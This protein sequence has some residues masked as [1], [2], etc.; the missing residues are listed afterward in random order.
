MR[1]KLASWAFVMAI[2]VVLM[3][4]PSH[5]AD[6]KIYPAS[7]CQVT[8]GNADDLWYRSSSRLEN[9]GS[10]LI[11][12][13]CPVVRDLPL[14]DEPTA[15]VYGR[16]VHYG[17]Q[18]LKCRLNIRMSNGG[19]RLGTWH[20]MTGVGPWNIDPS[21][22]GAGTADA[23]NLECQI[24]GSYTVCDNFGGT[25]ICSTSYSRLDHYIVF[26]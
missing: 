20:T 8:D 22:W 13:S 18:D 19:R 3:A 12:V 10:S 1:R 21:A 4:A 25:I 16:D 9:H 11:T 6:T 5:A 26:E 14:Q 7:G 2:P 23:M 17:S 24:P 15:D